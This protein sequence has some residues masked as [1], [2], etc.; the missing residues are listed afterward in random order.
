MANCIKT[1]TLRLLSLRTNQLTATEAKIW[2][3]TCLAKNRSLKSYGVWRYSSTHSLFR[4]E[5]VLGGQ[6]RRVYSPDKATRCLTEYEARWVSRAC[7]GAVENRMQ[8][9]RR[10]VLP[11]YSLMTRGTELCLTT[12]VSWDVTQCHWVFEPLKI[13]ANI[14]RNVRTIKRHIPEPLGRQQ[15]RCVIPIHPSEH[16]LKA[17]ECDDITM[18]VSSCAAA[19][20]CTDRVV[21]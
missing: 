13:E 4:Q 21:H 11:H 6:C 14:V 12:Q 10:R 15:D 17:E 18:S 19:A 8:W 2:Y 7:D 9:G 5:V 20:P 1:R 16:V 3:C